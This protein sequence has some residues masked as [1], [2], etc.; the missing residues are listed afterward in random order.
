MWK[1]MENGAGGGGGS[2]VYLYKDG[3]I[4]TALTGGF[5]SN[6]ATFNTNTIDMSS[7]QGAYVLTNN[8]IDLSN[9]TKVGFKANYQH[10]SSSGTFT[11]VK[12]GTTTSN[13][14][15]KAAMT[16]EGL[17]TPTFNI[18]QTVYGY[19]DDISTSNYVSVNFQ[20]NGTGAN[21]ISIKEIWLEP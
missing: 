13:L 19:I 3:E 5:S 11:Y 18:D 4:N 20:R 14:V 17:G 10:N 1:R 7:N 15:A 9:Y 6:Y 2:R 8:A 12:V 21:A 16:P